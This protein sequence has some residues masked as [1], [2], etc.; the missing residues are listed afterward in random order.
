MKD[1]EC[2]Y[3]GHEQDVCHDDGFGYEED[4]AHEVECRGCEK[5][6]QFYTN[7]SFSYEVNAADCLN[8]GAHTYKKTRTY[9]PQFSCLRCEVCGDEKPIPKATGGQS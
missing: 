5:L 7:I 3:C 2:P 1:L 6:F 9:P 4:I 8:N